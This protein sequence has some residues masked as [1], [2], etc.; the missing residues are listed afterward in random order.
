MKDIEWLAGPEQKGRRSGSEDEARAAAWIA[1]ALDDAKIP[2]WEDQRVVPFTYSANAPK[3]SANVVGVIE[4]HGADRR[5]VIVLGAHY[6]HLGE[7]N[8]K[9]YYGAEDNA[10]GTAVVLAIARALEARRGEL[11]RRVVIAFF[12]AEEMGLHGSQAMVKTW[13]FKK[14]PVTA[15]VNVDMIG[16]P[17]VDQPALWLTA[18]LFGV[19]SDVE[20]AKAVGVMLPDKA[21][22]ELQKTVTDACAAHGIRAVYTSDLPDALR[23]KVEQIAKGRSDHAPFEEKN[24]PFA[25]FSS[26]ESTD[27]HEPTDTPDRLTPSILEAR[28]RAILDVV[29]A[30]SK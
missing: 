5:E 15:M 13:D 19:L 12:G 17:L 18:R 7:R 22:P 8:G 1:K 11:G 30:L 28:A 16:R 27:Y 20:P 29:I 2:K 9:V 23:A 14:H 3:K 10:S 21:S 25:F 6:D 4:P 26:G 24:V